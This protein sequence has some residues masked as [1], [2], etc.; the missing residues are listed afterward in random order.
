MT[1]REEFEAWYADQEKYGDAH[2]ADLLKCWQAAKAQ[3][4]LEVNEQL[5]QSLCD[6]VEIVGESIHAGHWALR[7]GK[8]KKVF[9]TPAASVK[10]VETDEERQQREREEWCKKASFIIPS[11]TGG[12]ISDL[13]FIHDALV[14][15]ELK[16]PG[17]VK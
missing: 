17:V 6:M 3:A 2:K 16:M 5:L 13:G 14:S 4:A 15:G 7:D 9:H 12:L 8:T 1:Q 11:V 10:P